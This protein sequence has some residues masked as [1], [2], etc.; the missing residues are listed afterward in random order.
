MLAVKH[1]QGNNELL[2]RI[3]R[4][5]AILQG[6]C[7]TNVSYS[8]RR[9]RPWVRTRHVRRRQSYSLLSNQPLTTCA[10]LTGFEPAILLVRSQV[11]CPVWPQVDTYT[12]LTYPE[13]DSNS[14]NTGRKPDALAR[15][16]Y[17]GKNN[18]AISSGSGI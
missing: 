9:A 13:R 18:W 4:A 6:W 7:S 11:P 14:R 10:D 1:H 5:S 16:S 15:L 3:E 17:P 8:S 12:L 2:T